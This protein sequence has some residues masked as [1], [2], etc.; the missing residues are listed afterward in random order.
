MELDMV[1]QSLPFL[2]LCGIGEIFAG[3][4]FGNMV[5][6]FQ[7]YPGL[8][9]IMP[10]V[11]GMRGNIVTTLGSRLGS[12][13]HLGVIDPEDVMGNP[14]THE[15]IYATFILSLTMA[16]IVAVVAFTSSVISGVETISLPSLIFVTVLSAIIAGTFL[17]SITIMIMKLSFKRGLDPDNVTAPILTTVGDIISIVTIY[18]VVITLAEL[19]VMW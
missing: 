5:D 18:I 10:A 16:V 1:K 7:E 2:I 13:I 8:I 14:E 17:I 4:L 19:G 15:N 11:I 9:I 3:S 12:S 6:L